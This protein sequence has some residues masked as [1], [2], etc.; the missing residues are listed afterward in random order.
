[1]EAGKLYDLT[2]HDEFNPNATPLQLSGVR[3]PVEF[4][5]VD[6]WK[7]KT[8]AKDGLYRLRITEQGNPLS[9]TDSTF[10]TLSDAMAPPMVAATTL[11]KIDRAWQALLSASPSLGD[12]LA[13]LLT[14]PLSVTV[15]PPAKPGLASTARP[16]LKY[17][18]PFCVWL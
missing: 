6:E 2:I 9:A 13:E 16:E 8:L 17:A 1:M 7:G 10:R 14:L 3:P 5:K 18:D 4:S 15:K 12:A 11:E